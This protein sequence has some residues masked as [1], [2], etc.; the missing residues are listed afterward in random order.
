MRF[1]R[2]DFGCDLGS[3][4]GFE[5][6]TDRSEADRIAKRWIDENPEET[7]LVKVVDITPTKTGIKRALNLYATHPDNG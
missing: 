2:V 1:Y 3:S 5:W 4:A 6:F 7:A